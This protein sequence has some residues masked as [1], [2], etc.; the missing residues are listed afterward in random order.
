MQA[1]DEIQY[2]FVHANGPYPGAYSQSRQTIKKYLNRQ[3]NTTH[4]TIVFK[5]ELCQKTT[6]YYYETNTTNN[7]YYHDTV[8][9]T[10]YPDSNFLN[11]LPLEPFFDGFQW[12]YFNKVDNM[13]YQPEHVFM[14][15]DDSLVLSYISNTWTTTYYFINLGNETFHF[16]N[17]YNSD[18]DIQEFHYYK[19]NGIE[20]GTPYICSSLLAVDNEINFQE[21][22]NIYPIPANNFVTIENSTPFPFSTIEIFDLQGRGLCS[23]NVTDYYQTIDISGIPAGIYF[24]KMESKQTSFVRKLIITK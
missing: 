17:Y 4:D 7:N 16:N 5:I 11:L 10:I 15:N 1:G 20:W 14:Y 9:Q 13:G 18:E 2:D 21:N 19:I 22:F 6:T 23:I 12:G 3:D 24:I 8:Y